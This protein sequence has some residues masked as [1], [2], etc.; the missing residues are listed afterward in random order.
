MG[1]HD[2]VTPHNFDVT[3]TGRDGHLVQARVHLRETI[4]VGG[5]ELDVVWDRANGRVV[6]VTPW[7][8]LGEFVTAELARVAGGHA[9]H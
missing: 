2:P 4:P 3:L 1:S 6:S 8:N 7:R 5:I 9:A